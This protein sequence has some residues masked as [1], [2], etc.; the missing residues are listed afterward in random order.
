MLSSALQRKNGRSIRQQNMSN[1]RV[2]G[3]SFGLNAM[4][5]SGTIAGG[6][7]SS[8]ITAPNITIATFTRGALVAVNHH[9]H[10][11]G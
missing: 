8:A 1:H 6:I 4:S 11:L 3:I 7:T 9:H 2:T 10:H 5:S